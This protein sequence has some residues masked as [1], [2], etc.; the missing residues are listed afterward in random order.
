MRGS[1]DGILLEDALRRLKLP[2][3]LRDYR[4]CARQARETSDS[5]E[6]FLLAVASHEL[7]QR[8]QRQQERRLAEAHLRMGE[9]KLTKK[10]LGGED[11]SCLHVF[12]ESRLE[13][14]ESAFLS[15]GF[16]LERIQPTTN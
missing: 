3:M 14:T 9:V 13:A 8:Q 16:T 1:A 12:D 11:M 15:V 5:Y 10:P 7:E 2:A 4:E 6:S